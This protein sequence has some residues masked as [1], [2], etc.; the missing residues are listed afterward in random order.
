MQSKS[1]SRAAPLLAPSAPSIYAKNIQGAMTETAQYQS[2][3]TFITNLISCLIS[4]SSTITI[5]WAA[6]AQQKT[7]SG[8]DQ[9]GWTDHETRHLRNV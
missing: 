5:H 7:L 8:A 4:A 6:T 1:L 2:L 3:L 9:W